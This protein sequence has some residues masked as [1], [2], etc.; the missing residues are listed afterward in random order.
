MTKVY[1]TGLGIITTLGDSLESN[2]NGLKEGRCGIGSLDF[3][4]TKYAG[5]LLFGE[6]KLP[7]NQLKEL[8]NVKE[9]GVSR[10]SL[11]ALHAF[12]QAVNN[13]G[14]TSKDFSSKD[15]ALIC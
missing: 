3:F 8:L 13:A 2:R 5:S 14:L 12:N 6:I 9:A 1:V 15:T 7:N 4:S 10:T 11:L